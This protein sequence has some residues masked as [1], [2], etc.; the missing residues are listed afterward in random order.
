MST[1]LQNQT[2]KK[3]SDLWLPEDGWVEG[4][5]ELEE[6]SQKAKTF[7]YKMNK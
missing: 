1:V 4:R 2:Q 3:T 7:C 5:I 6:D